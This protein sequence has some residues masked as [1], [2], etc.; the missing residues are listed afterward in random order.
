MNFF[1]SKLFQ[2][3]PH[4]PAAV[5]SS[6]VC[7]G[8]TRRPTS[9]DR[10]SLDDVQNGGCPSSI[11]KFLSHTG[12]LTT[13]LLLFQLNMQSSSDAPPS[14]HVLLVSN[15]RGQNSSHTKCRDPLNFTQQN[16]V[17][18]LQKLFC[19]HLGSRGLAHWAPRCRSG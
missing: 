4:P 6:V 12:N 18:L 1:Q 17:N 3:L 2:A 14:S 15:L 11:H 13:I 9:L 8:S 10:P 7:G 19:V 16:L 5:H